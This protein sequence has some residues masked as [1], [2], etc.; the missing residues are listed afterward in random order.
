[1][2]TMENAVTSLSDGAPPIERIPPGIQL[3][4]VVSS[5]FVQ[6]SLNHVGMQSLGRLV[7][8]L[9]VAK[10]LGIGRLEFPALVRRHSG[11]FNS[12]PFIAPLGIGALARLEHDRVR[13]S[14][15]VPEGMI[16]RFAERVS[17]PLGAVGDE[18]FWVT[19]RPHAVLAGVLVA[20]VAG[21]WGAWVLLGLFAAWQS[22]YRWNTFTWGWQAGERVGTVLRGE[23]IRKPARYAGIAASACAGAAV[24]FAWA[25]F[26][27]L[28]PGAQLATVA[29]LGAAAGGAVVVYRRKPAT[30]AFLA[31]VVWS[32][33]L[34][35]ANSIF[36]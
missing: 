9:P 3:R 10:W 1:M 22:W 30:W 4:S 31:G 26:G 19:I 5:F 6:S 32:L 25:Q 24:V 34:S 35:V 13:V 27:V 14:S 28:V 20:L 18:L 29:F 33:A 8:L 23:P 12:N 15:S 36:R 7:C 11:L 2:T 21:A 17:T 16:E